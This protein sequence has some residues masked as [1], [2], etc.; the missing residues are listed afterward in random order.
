MLLETPF[1][2]PPHREASRDG[3]TRPAAAASTLQETA[4]EQWQ[5]VATT[6]PELALAQAEGNRGSLAK[7]RAPAQTDHRAGGASHLEGERK[8]R[9]APQPQSDGCRHMRVGK[10]GIDHRARTQGRIK[11]CKQV[12]GKRTSQGPAGETSEDHRHAE[13]YRSYGEGP[14]PPTSY[15][16]KDASQGDL[17]K[18]RV[19]QAGASLST[20]KAPV[21]GGRSGAQG[22]KRRCPVVSS[23]TDD[24]HETLKAAKMED[25][26]DQEDQRVI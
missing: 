23:S 7:L 12:D 9:R 4:T 15:S 5:P 6:S 24:G 1:E 16:K 2:D 19:G 11:S 3:A 21:M 26:D 13:V 22:K 10:A 17:R 18:P 25:K 20:P 14:R 8:G